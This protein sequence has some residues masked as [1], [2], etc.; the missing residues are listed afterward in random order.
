MSILRTLP[1]ALFLL[2]LAACDTATTDDYPIAYDLIDTEAE[3]IVRSNVSNALRGPFGPA[4]DSLSTLLPVSLPSVAVI[5]ASGNID[6]DNPT[7]GAAAT[8]ALLNGE[9]IV[10]L[11]EG[12]ADVRSQL[13]RALTA[14][15]Q[16]DGF[17]L[18]VDPQTGRAAGVSA[19]LLVVA[20]TEERL[21]AAL[22][23]RS[24]ASLDPELRELL[25]QIDRATLGAV[26]RDA[27]TLFTSFFGDTP[28]PFDPGSLP[29]RRFAA[30]VEPAD[31]DGVLVS[32]VTAWLK[33][34]GTTAEDLAQMLR[35]LAAIAAQDTSL[36]AETRALLTGLDP[37]VDSDYVRIRL[38]ISAARLFGM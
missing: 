24:S 10:S 28:L 17:S 20:P 14:D 16:A 37:V 32:V 29:V 12:T 4:L 8:D 33:P 1:A 11:P 26:F 38:E 35:A 34:R 6:T 25:W 18:F 36:D 21:R 13:A 9:Y 30:N 3:I 19:D 22:G 7:V 23:R 31:R 27:S 5:Y 2:L 15:G